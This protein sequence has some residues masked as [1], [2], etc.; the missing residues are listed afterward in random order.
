MLCDDDNNMV[1]RIV[2]FLVDGIKWYTKDPFGLPWV[3]KKFSLILPPFKQVLV[4]SKTSAGLP[5][6]LQ[7]GI[8]HYH[9]FHQDCPVFFPLLRHQHQQQ[10]FKQQCTQ[11]YAFNNGKC[12]LLHG[13]HISVCSR[14]FSSFSVCLHV[15]MFTEAVVAIV[16][17]DIQTSVYAAAAVIAVKAESLTLLYVIL[18]SW[19]LL[20]WLGEGERRRESVCAPNIFYCA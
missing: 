4:H 1:I 18:L 6:L 15:R 14:Y 10:L 17:V 16:G 9:D 5:L 13:S 20:P 2:Y 8:I 3:Q 7:L 19:L 11:F 12:V